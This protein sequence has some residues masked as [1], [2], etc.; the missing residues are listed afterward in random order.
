MQR[1]SWTINL[2][3]TWRK[4]R[5]RRKRKR[6][7]G[8]WE[9]GR[10]KCGLGKTE[11]EMEMFG[12]VVTATCIASG[13]VRIPLASTLVLGPAIEGYYL[14]QGATTYLP[15]GVGGHLLKEQPPLAKAEGL[16]HCVQLSFPCILSKPCFVTLISDRV[17]KCFWNFWDFVRKQFFWLFFLLRTWVFYTSKG[18]TDLILEIRKLSLREVTKRLLW[19]TTRAQV[20]WFEDHVTSPCKTASLSLSYEFIIIDGVFSMLYPIFWE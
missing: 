11:K 18:V 8:R 1:K 20:L 14:C 12:M 2:R 16:M 15:W 13:V 7:R 17:L 5:R 10:Q 9:K 4:R 6:G 3:H 19:V